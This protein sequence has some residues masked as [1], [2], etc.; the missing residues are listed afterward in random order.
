MKETELT[1]YASG[2]EVGGKT[3]SNEKEMKQGETGRILP[4]RIKQPMHE[5]SAERNVLNGYGVTKTQYTKMTIPQR[6]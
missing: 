1:R 4:D 6:K 2:R 5:N 3:S